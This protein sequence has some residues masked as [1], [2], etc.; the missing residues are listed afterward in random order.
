MIR[1]TVCAKTKLTDA[2]TLVLLNLEFILLTETAYHNINLIHYS[3]FKWVKSLVKIISRIISET[4][5]NA[6]E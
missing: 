4:R 3:I 6:Y 1:V 2:P 5:K